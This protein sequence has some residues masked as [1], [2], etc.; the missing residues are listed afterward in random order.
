MKKR[1]SYITLI[2]D[3]YIF[4]SI[5]L[6]VYGVFFGFAEIGKNSFYLLEVN[7]NI[8]IMIS[9]MEIIVNLIIAYLI[10]RFNIKSIKI[11]LIIM[12]ILLII[13][14]IINLKIELSM[15]LLWSLSISLG[16]LLNLFLVGKK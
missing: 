16:L 12:T 3:L 15:Y 7:D 9:I 2:S 11:L 8:Y 1:L 13:Y 4:M 5:I 14:E 6:I 10:H